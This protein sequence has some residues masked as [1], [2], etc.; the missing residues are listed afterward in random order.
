MLCSSTDGVLLMQMLAGIAAHT[1]DVS[2]DVSELTDALL[3]KG[4][5]C[6]IIQICVG[7]SL[8]CDF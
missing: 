3:D 8:T 7:L 1:A 6:N 2:R 5:I 4:I